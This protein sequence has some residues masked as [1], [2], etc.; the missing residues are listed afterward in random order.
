MGSRIVLSSEQWTQILDTIAAARP[1]D[2]DD[3]GVQ[4]AATGRDLTPD[5]V[6]ERR[7]EN[8]RIRLTA[9]TEY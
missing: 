3:T 5:E 8:R 4:D 6:N 7:T 9:P 2:P 1:A